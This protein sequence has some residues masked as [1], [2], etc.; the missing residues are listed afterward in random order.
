MGV[1]VVMLVVVV[2]LAGVGRRAWAGCV[3]RSR[4]AEVRGDAAPPLGCH[5]WLHD[6]SLSGTI[7]PQLS[8]LAQLDILCAAAISP[9]SS[10]SIPAAPCPLLRPSPIGS[11]APRPHPPIGP[12]WCVG[13]R[14]TTGPAPCWLCAAA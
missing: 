7:P 10:L 1:V 2:V 3:R 14:L 13:P 5:R 12:G 11:H 9:P 8:K 4:R 6:N